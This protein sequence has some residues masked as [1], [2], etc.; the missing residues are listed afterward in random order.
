MVMEDAGTRDRLALAR[1]ELANERTLLAYVRTA[2]SLMAA[3]AVLLQ[4]FSTNVTV[5]ASGWGL[6]ILGGCVLLFG[7]SRFVRV[8]SRLKPSISSETD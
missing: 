4:F 6:V 2:L 5:V 8:R 7:L 3:G 1:T